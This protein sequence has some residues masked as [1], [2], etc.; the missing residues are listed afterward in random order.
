M[1][2]ILLIGLLQGMQRKEAPFCY[3]DTHAGCGWYNLASAPAQ[4]TGEYKQ[5]LVKLWF[6][7]LELLRKEQNSKGFYGG[8][9]WFALQMMRPQDRMALMELHPVTRRSCG[10]I[11]G[12]TPMSPCITVT[13]MKALRR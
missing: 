10:I 8:S 12:A 7:Q 1:K 13:P 6:S 4:K 5:G 2:H 9:P 3:I 11:S